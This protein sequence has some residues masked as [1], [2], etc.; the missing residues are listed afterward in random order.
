MNDDPF[1]LSLFSFPF[2]PFFFPHFLFFLL[3]D[4]KQGNEIGN[5]D[6][7]EHACFS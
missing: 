4:T 5:D 7:Y 6:G 2:F 3:D 1:F